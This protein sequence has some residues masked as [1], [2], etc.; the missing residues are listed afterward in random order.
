[1]R[2]STVVLAL[3]LAAPP[4]SAADLVRLVRLKLSAGDLTTG[5]AAVEDYKLATGVDAEYLDA[6]GWL[7]RGAQMQGR[8]EL[9]Q[10]LVAE[11]R[12]EIKTETP[13]SLT[14]WGALI[15]VEGRLIAAQSG[16]GAAI[17]YFENALLKA[18]APSLRSRISKNINLLSLEG[19]RA[20]AI[21]NA[22]E[23]S[24]GKP[25]LLYF[26]AEW[27]GDCKAQAPS[28]TRV[29]EEYAPRGVDVI[30]VTRLY[31]GSKDK[32]Y[33]P[34]EE[35]AQVAKV[36]K[37]VYPGLADVAVVI[38]NDAMIRYGASATPT[39]ALV[40]RKGIVRLY[41]PTRLSEAEMSRWLEE[42]L[43]EGT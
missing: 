36:W 7:A 3:L 9:A 2:I 17:R 12:R 42:L 16:R 31:G 29:R 1:M 32:P 15:E 28:L 37:E 26:F 19:Q 14:P 23:S 25:V 20:P 21:G 40:D 6:I 4:A 39:F 13:E 22:L 38:D 11:L 30:A 35:K 5:M 33:T 18:N 27:C 34:D 10:Q 24:R 43:A 8:D 41:T